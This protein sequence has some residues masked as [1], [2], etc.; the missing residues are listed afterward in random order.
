MSLWVCTSPNI[1]VRVCVQVYLWVVSMRFLGDTICHLSLHVVHHRLLQAGKWTQNA[2][3]NV[4]V[5]VNTIMC[6]VLFT[7]IARTGSQ[8]PLFFHLW[9]KTIFYT[10]F[11][12]MLCT[13]IC[14]EHVP[15]WCA[16][17]PFW[18]LTLS[19]QAGG[20]RKLCQSHYSFNT[21]WMNIKES[22]Q[23]FLTNSRAEMHTR[24]G[25]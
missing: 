18:R 10:T 19:V 5:Y 1:F 15:A 9:F 22:K 13:K 12:N 25:L 23:C 17:A 11:C 20:E 14:A 24:T 6:T 4:C 3:H 7:K 8:S 21:A 2:F 16:L